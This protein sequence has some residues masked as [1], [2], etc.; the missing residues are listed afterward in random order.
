MGAARRAS[1]RHQSE[2]PPRR[3]ASS[4]AAARA[5]V[6]RAGGA[7]FGLV[8]GRGGAAVVVVAVVQRRD[9]LGA[10]RDLVDRAAGPLL[11]DVADV[12]ARVRAPEPVLEE[13]AHRPRDPDLLALRAT[14]P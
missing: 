12:V 11:A 13:R 3:S 7:G 6:R 14:C 5:A 9:P 8:V 2:P 1:P 4:S 10:L